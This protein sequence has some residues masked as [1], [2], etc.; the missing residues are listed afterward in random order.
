MMSS[1]TGRAVSPLDALVDAHILTMSMG[2]RLSGLVH[3]IHPQVL[4]AIP[5]V[6]TLWSP[7]V[8]QWP[9]LRKQLHYHLFRLHTGIPL[10]HSKEY[11]LN[12]QSHLCEVGPI[13]M[14]EA[15]SPLFG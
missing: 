3:V 2:E 12:D 6:V 15:V 5:F 9:K 1:E 7:H 11:H 14:H 4:T 8:M 13:T 10:Q